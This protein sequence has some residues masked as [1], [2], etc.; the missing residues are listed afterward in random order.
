MEV[1]LIISEKYPLISSEGNSG[2][3][4]DPLKDAKRAMSK[5]ALPPQRERRST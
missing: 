3:G 2:R 4:P 1:P 5:E